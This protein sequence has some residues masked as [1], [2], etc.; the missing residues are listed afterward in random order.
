MTATASPPL[1]DLSLKLLRAA[2][3]KV[4]RAQRSS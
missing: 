2:Q 4:I 1:S 3:Q